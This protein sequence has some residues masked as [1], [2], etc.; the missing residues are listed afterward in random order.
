MNDYSAYANIGHNS[1]PDKLLTITKLAEEQFAA[2]QNV[3][4]LTNSL[5]IATEELRKIAEQKLPE[6]ME[7]AGVNKFTTTKGI[8]IEVKEKVRASLPKEQ[9]VTGYDWME[10]N[11][12][13]AAIESEVIVSFQRDEID[14]A[15]E[16]VR[17]LRDQNRIANF[18]RSVHHSRLNSILCE[19]LANGE[20]V[21][22]EIFSVYRQR[23]A[24]VEI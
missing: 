14:E 11:G 22:L 16:F 10:K 15:K 12:L 7:E 8:H 17:F 1:D 13:G 19:R 6:A 23:V 5:K 21:P 2:Q 20:D 4:S 18:E 24:K 9:Q 3:D